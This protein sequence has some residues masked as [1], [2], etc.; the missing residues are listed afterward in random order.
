MEKGRIFAVVVIGKSS[1]SACLVE[2]QM[3][4]QAAAI[5]GQVRTDCALGEWW[6]R[7]GVLVRDLAF[8]EIVVE[9]DVWWDDVFGWSG[10]VTAKSQPKLIEWAKES[11][12][13]KA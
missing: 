3:P 9:C 10:H 12:W 7:F 1:S 13:G 8:P 4:E 6:N 5:C 11:G 2:A